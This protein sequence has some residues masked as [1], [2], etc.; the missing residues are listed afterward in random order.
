METV[1][2]RCDGDLE[3]FWILGL[4][5]KGLHFARA[6]VNAGDILKPYLEVSFSWFTEEEGFT[7]SLPFWPLPFPRKENLMEPNGGDA[8]PATEKV[9]RRPQAQEEEVR[10]LRNHREGERGRTSLGLSRWLCEKFSWGFR[11][12]WKNCFV[13][14][15]WL[16]TLFYNS[17]TS[18]LMDY[19][20]ISVFSEDG[21]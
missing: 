18:L 21:G 3:T 4:C 7:L 15:S 19:E 5:W 20:C 2:I 13:P 9:E 8:W 16:C 1:F 12:Q 17:K 6:F 14:C 10:H 11:E